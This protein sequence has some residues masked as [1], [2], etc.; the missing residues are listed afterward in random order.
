MRRPTLAL[1]P[2]LKRGV[3][4]LQKAIFDFPID[5]ALHFVIST[6]DRNMGAKEV[7]YNEPHGAERGREELRIDH[8][9]DS[10]VT[11]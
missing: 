11:F 2:Q 10:L 1:R 3:L 9:K 5:Q 8:R 4:H 7:F 6:H